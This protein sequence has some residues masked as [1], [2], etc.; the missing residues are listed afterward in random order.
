MR[1]QLRCLSNV[2]LGEELVEACDLVVG[3]L[4]E[5]PCEPRLWVNVIQFGGFDQSEGDS[6]GFAAALGAREHPVL[7]VNGDRF[8]RAFGCV[9]VELQMAM[10]MRPTVGYGSIGI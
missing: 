1:E 3:D 7:P 10:L 8:D 6:H 4:A 5:H 9:V 2:P